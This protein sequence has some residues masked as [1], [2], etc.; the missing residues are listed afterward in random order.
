MIQNN[1]NSIAIAQANTQLNLFINDITK[2][3]D[4]LLSTNDI[5]AIMTEWN[6]WTDSSLNKYQKNC[7]SASYDRWVQTIELC[8]SDYT[9]SAGG[10]IL[11]N[12]NCIIFT[13]FSGGQAYSRYSI[14]TGCANSG[15][16]DFN[17]VAQAAA[18]YTTNINKYY[19]DNK[20]LANQIITNN[21]N[22]EKSFVGMSGKLMGSLDKVEG[23][24]TPLVSIFQSLVGDKGLFT[25]IDC[26]KFIFYFSFHG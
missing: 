23:I 20:D 4:P 21:N 24:I 8:P 14:Q 3:T 12:K 15:S 9:A 25:L 10:G 5:S 1:T 17:S 26:G 22:L 7:N 18:N 2:T 11:G 13:D 16:P 19:N 6:E